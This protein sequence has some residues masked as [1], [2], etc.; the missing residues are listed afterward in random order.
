MQELTSMKGFPGPWRAL[1]ASSFSHYFISLAWFSFFFCSGFPA[2]G[3]FKPALWSPHPAAL[4]AL[5]CPHVSFR[6]WETRFPTWGQC[7]FKRTL[8][9]VSSRREPCFPVCSFLVWVRWST[10]SVTLRWRA[11]GNSIVVTVKELRHNRPVTERETEWE[12]N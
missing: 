12:M 2:E 4:C 10:M 6:G 9:N 7:C 11:C 8:H 3:T 5:F 1:S